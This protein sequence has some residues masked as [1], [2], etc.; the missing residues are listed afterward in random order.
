[1]MPATV[2][3]P[4]TMAHTCEGKQLVEMAVT[5]VHLY[6]IVVQLLFC[7]LL[8][9]NYAKLKFMYLLLLESDK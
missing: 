4:P 2:K 6:H 1:M 3:V 7:T 9:N 5:F 8:N